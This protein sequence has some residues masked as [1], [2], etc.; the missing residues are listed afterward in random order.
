MEFNG[1]PFINGKRLRWR[2]RRGTQELDR[3]LG[4]FL[5]QCSVGENLTVQ[6]SFAD[7]LEAP[8]SDLWDWLT[9]RSQPENLRWRSIIEQIR[10]HHYL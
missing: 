9:G 1:D 4:W 5:E 7:L 3:L 2:C 6:A 8:D 10:T